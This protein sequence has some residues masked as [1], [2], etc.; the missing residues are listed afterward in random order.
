M[1][2]NLSSFNNTFAENT[3]ELRATL[4][5]VNDSYQKQAEMMR[6]INRLKIG[7]IASANIEVYD[8]L[9]NSTNEIGIFA[10]YLSN[11]NEFL[12]NIQTLNRKLDDYERRTQIIESAGKFFA[13]NEK[14]LAE[15]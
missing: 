11:A 3:K 2:R 8:K 10:Q 12:S 1:T 13:K 5:Q 9:R 7:E 6:A 14:W 4:S 15:N